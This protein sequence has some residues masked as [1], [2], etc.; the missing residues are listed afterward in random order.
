[1]LNSLT[2]SCYSEASTS[3][4][5]VTESDQVSEA[6]EERPCLTLEIR[7][8]TA[9]SVTDGDKN[10]EVFTNCPDNSSDKS[11]EFEEYNSVL[12]NVAMCDHEAPETKELLQDCMGPVNMDQEHTVTPAAVTCVAESPERPAEVRIQSNYHKE[13]TSSG[14]GNKTGD[15]VD[16]V[17]TSQLYSSCTDSVLV[18]DQTINSDDSTSRSCPDE[19]D[20]ARHDD[21]I[22]SVDRNET[23]DEAERLSA[24]TLEMFFE[25]VDEAA[26]DCSASLRRKETRRP[27]DENLMFVHNNESNETECLSSKTSE[28]S[29]E[30]S[31]DRAVF[32]LRE[33]VVFHDDTTCL[34]PPESNSDEYVNTTDQRFDAAEDVVE[35]AK[36]DHSGEE[37]EVVHVDYDDDTSYLFSSQGDSTGEYPSN[38]VSQQDHAFEDEK[39]AKSPNGDESS[40]V[41]QNCLA[42]SFDISAE[43][44]ENC[45]VE[46]VAMCGHEVAET[47]EILDG[48]ESGNLDRNHL[49][50]NEENHLSMSRRDA[51]YGK[52]LP[53]SKDAFQSRHISAFEES[54]P[55]YKHAIIEH[56]HTAEHCGQ[57]ELIPPTTDILDDFT[58]SQCNQPHTQQ[59]QPLT[60]QLSVDKVVNFTVPQAVA[61]PLDTAGSETTMRCKDTDVEQQT[62]MSV[63]ASV[64]ERLV[65]INAVG[66]FSNMVIHEPG[67]IHG[68]KN[69]L[70]KAVDVSVLNSSNREECSG[71]NVVALTD[72]E[73]KEIGDGYVDS[74]VGDT[75]NSGLPGSSRVS[76]KREL[77]DCASETDKDDAK[78]CKDLVKTSPSTDDDDNNDYDTVSMAANA[79]PD[80]EDLEADVDADIDKN[81]V[82]HNTFLLSSY[83]ETKAA[84]AEVFV[85]A[86]AATIANSEEEEE[87]ES[88]DCD[89]SIDLSSSEMC[90]SDSESDS[91]AESSSE[92]CYSSDDVVDDTDV[93]DTDE[94]DDLALE[95]SAEHGNVGVVGYDVPDNS[96]HGHSKYENGKHQ[97]PR[98]FNVHSGTSVVTRAAVDTELS[99][100]SCSSCEKSEH[101]EVLD[102]EEE[103]DSRSTTEATTTDCSQEGTW[104]EGGKNVQLADTLN[105]TEL[106]NHSGSKSPLSETCDDSFATV[107]GNK[108]SGCSEHTL[109][110]CGNGD[111][112]IQLGLSEDC[113]SEFWWG[114]GTLKNH[115]VV[116]NRCG[117]QNQDDTDNNYSADD[118]DD[119]DFQGA[120]SAENPGLDKSIYIEHSSINANVCCYTV[121]SSKEKSTTPVH[122]TLH[123]HSLMDHFASVLDC[124]DYAQK[125][126]FNF[127]QGSNAEVFGIE[128]DEALE[129]SR[130]FEDGVFYVDCNEDQQLRSGKQLET[131]T[132]SVVP[133]TTE[134]AS[135]TTGVTRVA[136]DTDLSG[137]SC[138]SCDKSEHKY[139]DSEEQLEDVHLDA[140]SAVVPVMANDVDPGLVNS[141]PN[142]A[143]HIEYMDKLMSGGDA[144][145]DDSKKVHSKDDDVDDDYEIVLN[146]DV[147]EDPVVTESDRDVVIPVTTTKDTHMLSIL[148]N[149]S[150]LAGTSDD[151]GEHETS[152]HTVV[153]STDSGAEDTFF[154]GR[155][156]ET[157][158]AMALVTTTHELDT[159]HMDQSAEQVSDVAVLIEEFSLTT[160]T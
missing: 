7:S 26:A 4:P 51:N 8:V 35:T 78:N 152:G 36:C 99:G 67:E 150:L 33:K 87:E 154:S 74:D 17:V 121:A 16:Y 65:N 64:C 119:G 88:D 27:A 135:E 29:E 28:L 40:E 77:D 134:Q 118:D 144:E 79:T 92:S 138:S 3:S 71:P 21:N 122:S 22:A 148:D 30:Q 159:T 85:A 5:A 131:E 106:V 14:A 100:K 102:S 32:S 146:N 127:R 115:K 70:E 84:D 89:R 18:I 57:F 41:F 48:V 141:C 66:G 38:T 132:T 128:H 137:K 155:E 53:R 1:M 124:R 142:A 139:F 94:G 2:T 56:F 149:M 147:S 46:K 153:I 31:D 81:H 130:T 54:T 61:K 103:F 157:Q 23:G 82:N 113:S 93:G 117:L 58:I 44:G 104:S 15:A 45:A 105:S 43:S 112:C 143:S 80:K 19:A 91:E 75:C 69:H 13:T 151:M 108:D 123:M 34:I 55:A 68:G 49:D 59:S 107:P 129:L 73:R 72:A 76:E 24:K 60:L 6:L 160:E 97:E 9:K 111:K 114:N 47:K 136:V 90:K 50:G 133:G 116:E 63:L 98:T 12:A 96:E 125:D 52:R 62:G 145:N 37:S 83:L 120:D 39:S 20:L 140:R 25:P 158:P 86:T 95:G 10:C 101:K 156:L 110:E 109:K 11:A 126:L 42:A